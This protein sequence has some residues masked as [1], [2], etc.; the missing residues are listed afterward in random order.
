MGH[1]N[2]P[3]FESETVQPQALTA[4]AKKAIENIVERVERLEEEKATIAAEI[5]EVYA[6]AKAFGLD[7]KVLRK[8]VAYRK[9][10]RQEREEFQMILDLYLDALGLL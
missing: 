2:G 3:D 7:T 9:Q 4:T 10:D 5:K 1:N 8:V 6:E